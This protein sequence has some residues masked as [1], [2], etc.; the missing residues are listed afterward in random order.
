MGNI[1]LLAITIAAFTTTNSKLHMDSDNNMASALKRKRAPVEVLD[2]PKRAK[3]VEKQSGNLFQSS[4]G[5]DAFRPP[6]TNGEPKHTLSNGQLASPEAEAINLEEYVGD[7]LQKSVAVKE[8]S[9]AEN[10]AK[11]KKKEKKERRTKSWTSKPDREA[12]KISSP[13]GG[14]MIN[15]DPVF[16]TD[17]K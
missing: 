13:I 8:Q 10:P 17:E 7:R 15:A 5:W 12:W 1:F 14:R 11:K 16:T 4:P 2:T 6:T 9:R 3:S